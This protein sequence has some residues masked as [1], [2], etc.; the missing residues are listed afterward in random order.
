M[1]KDVV[2]FVFCLILF[3]CQKSLKTETKYNDSSVMSLEVDSIC[4]PLDSVSL[5]SY[6]SA[7][8]IYSTEHRTAMYAFNAK[9][10]MIDVFDLN[11]KCLAGHIT[12][13]KEGVYGVPSVNNIQVLSPDSIVCFVDDGLLIVN[14]KGTVLSREVLSYT[15]SD[16]VGNFD[17]GAFSQPFYDKNEKKVY[18]RIITSK[19]RYPYPAGQPLF[20]EYDVTT[21][22]WEFIPVTLPPFMEKYWQQMG[23]NRHLSMWIN[24][25]RICYNFSCFS[26]VFVYTM[27]ERK[28]R[29]AG[30]ES[31]LVSSEILPYTGDLQNEQARWEHWIN[32]PAFYAPVYD[33]YTNRYYRIQV[34]KLNE[35]IVG[36]PTPYDKEIVLAVFNGDLEMIAEFRLE[37]YKY[38]FLFFGV[39]QNGLIVG[40][41][42]P[43]DASIDYE[44]LKL[45]RLRIY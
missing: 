17:G 32:S 30:G 22:V 12:L 24:D 40:G 21:K 5:E 39:D 3:G 25:D 20:A 38:N 11:N 13:E 18:G 37:N 33:K 15:G 42:N 45:Y 43:K 23:Q 27:S 8:Y 16:C 6:P 36:K 28:V 34:G 14:G 2:L 4:I 1:M 10:W 29:S 19:E 9:T 44:Q 31:R 26:D 41:N 35:D 7:T